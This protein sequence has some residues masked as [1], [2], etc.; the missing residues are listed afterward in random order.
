M[1]FAA[2]FVHDIG[3][4]RM[5]AV[6][7][8]VQRNPRANEFSFRILSISAHLIHSPCSTEERSKGKCTFLEEKVTVEFYIVTDLYEEI[9]PQDEQCRADQGIC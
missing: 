1:F 7:V 3:Q 4:K 5:V 2:V 9:K 6:P 8:D